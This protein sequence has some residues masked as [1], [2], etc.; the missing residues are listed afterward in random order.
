MGVQPSPR[1][2]LLTSFCSTRKST[3]DA[4]CLVNHLWG[5]RWFGQFKI[6]MF[7]TQLGM[8]SVA[9]CL[10]GF[11]RQRQSAFW[12]SCQ[13]VAA[14]II[15]VFR[16]AL[17]F[18]PAHVALF[19]ESFSPEIFNFFWQHMTTHFLDSMRRIGGVIF[20][21]FLGYALAGSRCAWTSSQEEP[22]VEVCTVY[23]K[24]CFL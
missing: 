21:C 9:W 20:L 3:Y 19:G 15:A 16:W 4:H 10:R 14:V 18:G 13:S 5:T 11:I 8:N 1:I 6:G 12:F 17:D 22:L 24:F 23:S 7:H 2:G